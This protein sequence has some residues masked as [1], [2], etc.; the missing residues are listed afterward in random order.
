MLKTILSK[1]TFL[2]KEDKFL[3]ELLGYYTNQKLY[4]TAFIH[5]SV[6]QKT[7]N[8][9]LEFLGDAVLSL[10]TAELLF[11]ENPKQEE[12]F[13]SKKRATIISRKHLNIS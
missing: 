12:G 7:H 4:K 8:E 6:S 9:Q 10:I 3:F 11:L 1:V 5:K 13:L 2:K